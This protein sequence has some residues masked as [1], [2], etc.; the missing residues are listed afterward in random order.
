MFG[1]FYGLPGTYWHSFLANNKAP[2]FVDRLQQVGYQLGLFASAK[3][4]SPEFD[5]TVFSKVENL[6]LH[7]QGESAPERDINLTEEW[8]AWYKKRNNSK[9]IFSFCFMT[10]LMPMTFRRITQVNTSRYRSTLI[11]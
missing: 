6:R 8:E 1:L 4:T 10:P 11:T 5:Q 2:V 7:S 3:L 9:P